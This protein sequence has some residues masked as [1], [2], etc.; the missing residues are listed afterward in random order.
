[1]KH[2]KVHESS[3]RT[4]II[5][6]MVMHETFQK[7]LRSISI[8]ALKHGEDKS[9]HDFQYNTAWGAIRTKIHMSTKLKSQI[10]YNLVNQFI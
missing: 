4:S 7:W 9:K 10:S 1:M 2:D 3:R 8:E 6:H 5:K